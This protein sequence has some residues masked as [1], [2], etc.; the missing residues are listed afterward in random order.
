VIVAVMTTTMVLVTWAQLPFAMRA[1]GWSREELQNVTRKFQEDFTARHE[2]R[3]LGANEIQTRKYVAA[4]WER[5][6]ARWWAT[7]VQNVHATVIPFLATTTSALLLW[8]TGLG[9]LTQTLTIGTALAV[10]VLANTA[11]LPLRAFGSIYNQGLD[12]RVSWHRLAE[13]FAEPILPHDAPG[14]AECE[15]IAADT[16]VFDDV[17]FTYPST[18]RPVLSGASFSLVPGQITALVGYTGAG[19]SSI[20]KLFT[21]TYDPDSGR[22]TVGN[23]DIRTFTA[24]SYRARLGIVPQDPFIFRGTVAS[25]IR[26]GKPDATDDDVATALHAIGGEALLASLPAG[27]AAAVDEEGRNLTAAQRQIVALARAWLARPDV[28]VLDEATSLLDH[29]TEDRVIDAIHALGCTT[30]MITHREGV[31]ARSDRIVVLDAG[32]VVDEGTADVVAR[33]DGPYER[34]WR[35]VEPSDAVVGAAGSGTNHHLDPEGTT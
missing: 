4:C 18:T 13:P 31:A 26:Y 23:V 14:A 1:F 22:I 19:K 28:P 5:R 33:P 8:K 21:R 27:W 17:K 7:T 32:R 3:T 9:V 20:A 25:N 2:I 16:I 34:L 35:V 29:V 12:V 30:L 15:P 24:R 10:Q 6:R 11:T